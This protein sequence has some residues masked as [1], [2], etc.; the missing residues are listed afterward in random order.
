MSTTFVKKLDITP[1]LLNEMCIVSL[2]SGQNLTSWFSLKLYMSK[3][4]EENYQ[5]I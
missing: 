4:L 2:P 1:D 3:S 5:L